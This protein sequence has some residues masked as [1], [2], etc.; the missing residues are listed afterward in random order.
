MATVLRHFI[1]NMMDILKLICYLFVIMIYSNTVYAQP[2]FVNGEVRTV[3]GQVVQGASIKLKGSAV[4][5]LS[6]H[7]GFFSI[8]VA[9]DEGV[10][11]ISHLNF[12]SREVAITNTKL[13]INIVLQPIGRV[14][15]EVEVLNTGYYKLPKERATGSFEHINRAQ[16]ERSPSASLLDRIEGMASGL[17]FSR[18]KVNTEQGVSPDLRLRGVSSI[19]SNNAPLIILD[20]FPF[21]GDINS[22]NPEHVES[23]TL[24]KD[25]A[26]SSIWGVRAGNGVIVI[27][28]KRGNYDG[29]ATIQVD[30]RQ[31]I[32]TK[33][34]LFYNQARLP[35][36]TVLEIEDRL[37]DQGSYAQQNQL[38]IPY[39]ADMRYRLKNGK[40]TDEQFQKERNRLSQTDIRSDAL[41]YLYQ[42]QYQQQYGLSL[43]GGAKSHK[44]AFSAGY[45]NT[46]YNIR[47]NSD[48]RLTLDM[49]NEFK[50]TRDLIFD[51]RLSYAG[52]GQLKNGLGL[53]NLN[54]S[55]IGSYSTYNGLVDEFGKSMALVKDYSWEYVNSANELGLL[56][57]FYKPVD[58]LVLSENSSRQDNYRIAT[59]VRYQIANGLSASSSFQ[60][61]LN[62]LSNRVLH[63]KN[64]Y[65]VRNLVN[66]FTQNDGSR[67]IPYNGI[68]QITGNGKTTSNSFR[69]Q[70]NYTKKFN[71]DHEFVGLAGYER[72]ES[73]YNAMPNS[74][75]Y[76]YDHDLRIGST[77][78]DYTKSFSQRPN[79]SARI[80]GAGGSELRTIDRDLSYY[81]NFSYTFNDKYSLTQSLRWDASNLF[82]VK[83]NQKGVPLWSV[84]LAWIVSQESF[85][86]FDW[87]DYFKVRATYGSSGNV[88][89][90]VSVY[91]TARYDTNMESNL[92]FATLSSVGNPSLRWERV[93]T[94]NFGFD[95][96]VLDRRMQIA[97]DLY[98]KNANDLFGYDFDDPTVGLSGNLK[99]MVNYAQLKTTGADLNITTWN[100]KG[101]LSWKTN[102]LINFVKN[103]I[104]NYS[105]NKTQKAIDY[106]TD[107]GV[108][109]P[110]IG[111]SLDV[112]Y[113]FPWNGLSSNNGLPIVYIDGVES[114]DYNNYVSN[115]PVANLVDVGVRIPSFYGYLRNDLS[116]KSFDLSFMISWK[117]GYKFRR[118]SMVPGG[119]YQGY[120][121][122]HLDYFKRWKEA[123]DERNTNVPA[124]TD[125][126]TSAL[127][128][129]YSRSTELIESGDH[130]RWD[131]VVLSY[132]FVFPKSSLRM[133]TTFTVKNL[134]IIWRKNRNGIDPDVPFAYYPQP[135]TYTLGVN[136]DF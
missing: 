105:T 10:L 65:Y 124:M 125:K 67:I 57:W 69:F 112:M 81:G 60:Y 52:Q 26:A 78:Y 49:A 76:D 48:K 5:T 97:V 123:G 116:Y 133:R 100:V 93:N 34:D 35:S 91:P 2:Q 120:N 136:L 20:D 104:L 90:S 89:K 111:K 127:D 73:V 37:F 126:Y 12:T 103:E 68:L 63:D 56:D 14:L 31:T 94:T 109:P 87:L 30:S 50:I 129:A 85:F 27:T 121:Y 24:L 99:Q 96:A 132:K 38:A 64:S 71:D 118:N 108:S 62:N 102:A 6:D 19:N 83:T 40:I 16:L 130:I 122:H 28:T 101:K 39:Y 107:F 77:Q 98:N 128:R 43:A 58:E 92:R 54:S 86:K 117:G 114:Q 66:R 4:S 22:I 36:A 113:A 42:N 61:S 9:D 1:L 51:L 95:L 70:L 18:G 23:V 46:S 80:P 74:V 55:G 7:N 44:Y 59:N 15:E 75:L 29:K 79:G 47:K 41:K 21:D 17:Q 84:G 25:A 3:E 11:E 88:N 32:G 45:Y 13:R 131:D 106:F 135:K 119:E 82:G 115:F 134:G 33:P 53:S 8:K 72:R 110:T